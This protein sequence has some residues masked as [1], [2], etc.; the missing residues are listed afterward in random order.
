MKSTKWIKAFIL[1]P[2][3]FWFF[4]SCD[5]VEKLANRAPVIQ[6][7]IADPDTVSVSG[8]VFLTVEAKDPDHDEMTFTWDAKKGHFPNTKGNAVQ[9]VAPETE[10]IYNI[11]VTVRD[12]NGGE[13][14]DKI[15]ITVISEN[16]PTVHITQPNDGDFLVGLGKAEIRVDVIP[17][18]FIDRVEFYLNDELLGVDRHQP[19]SYS[20]EL[21]GLSG[22]KEIRCVAYRIGTGVIK[23]SDSIVV[24]IQG[25]VPIPLR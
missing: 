7:I 9:W 5:V 25:V 20:L 12:I 11:E 3:F 21:A 10:G 6:K 8:T 18:S 17:I 19:Y 2:I 1:L 14:K 15:S 23:G 13:S 4:A 22:K 16:R 24:N